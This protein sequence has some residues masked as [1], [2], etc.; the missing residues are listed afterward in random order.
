MT[1]RKQDPRQAFKA[2]AG[3]QDLSLCA[4]AAI[5]KEAVF[6]MRN[7]LSRKPAL[8]RWRGSGCAKK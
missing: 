8:C 3:L 2:D 4:F 7:D 5:D 1:V 6:V